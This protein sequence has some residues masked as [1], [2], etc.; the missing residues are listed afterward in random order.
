MRAVTSPRPL[1]HAATYHAPRPKTSFARR[2]GPAWDRFDNLTNFP[3]Y[4]GVR[5][6]RASV[7]AKR[8]VAQR[9]Y[10]TEG[11]CVSSPT[12]P[13]R[14]I[15]ASYLR[16]TYLSRAAIASSICNFIQVL[17]TTYPSKIRPE[18]RS[19]VVPASTP[20]HRP[21]V[22]APHLDR[23]LSRH[24]HTSPHRPRPSDA[25]LLLVHPRTTPS[26]SRALP[27]PPFHIPTLPLPPNPPVPRRLR[28]HRPVYG[29]PRICPARTICGS[30]GSMSACNPGDGARSIHEQKSLSDDSE[31]RCLDDPEAL[32]RA[33][34]TGTLDCEEAAEQPSPV[35][36]LVRESYAS[37]RYAPAA[38]HF[39]SCSCVFG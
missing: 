9:L 27:G 3:G 19:P 26:D 2:S 33:G 37:E 31:T 21:Q 12:P 23:G 17:P 5:H 8:L 28:P 7:V 24:R 14:I 39:P 25:H 30:S 36:C 34:E 13:S 10:H 29:S 4:R 22:T 18:S 16:F 6:A 35:L 32:G 15:R 1:H 20:G 38:V 11:P